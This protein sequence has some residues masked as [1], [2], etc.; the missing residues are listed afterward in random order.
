L[1]EA[2]AAGALYVPPEMADGVFAAASMASQWCRALRPRS[3]RCVALKSTLFALLVAPAAEL[4]AFSVMGMLLG[5]VLDAG[6]E[7]VGTLVTPGTHVRALPLAPLLVHAATWNEGACVFGALWAAHQLWVV[8]SSTPPSLLGAQL[9]PS[10]EYYAPRDEALSARE[11]SWRRTVAFLLSCECLELGPRVLDSLARIR[12]GHTCSRE[13][14]QGLL[15]VAP[16]VMRAARLPLAMLEPL[17]DAVGG[18]KN[19]HTASPRT[20]LPPGSAQC[21]WVVVAAC[22][23]VRDTVRHASSIRAT[24]LGVAYDTV[25]VGAGPELLR[26]KGSLLDKFAALETACARYT[27]LAALRGAL[28]SPTRDGIGVALRSHT[29]RM[30]T[31]VDVVGHRRVVAFIHNPVPSSLMP[32]LATASVLGRSLCL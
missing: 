25:C 32:A 19:G 9:G 1:E 31:E 11:A 20:P 2:M 28:A 26:F 6:M 15:R 27:R 10:T 13:L 7:T 18:N 8:R 16:A 29:R 5:A 23:R 22:L 30:R 24:A 3:W 4:E 12:V 14:L 17:S 21:V